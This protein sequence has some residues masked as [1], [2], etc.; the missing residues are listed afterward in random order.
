MVSGL[1]ILGG[2]VR[3]NNNTDK[4]YWNGVQD[5]MCLPWYGR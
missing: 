4:I 2:V 1:P 5:S 3:L